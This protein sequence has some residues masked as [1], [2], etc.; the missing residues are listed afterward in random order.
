MNGDVLIQ[1]IIN[2]FVMAI[3]LEAAIMAIFSM[4]AFRDM[5]MTR[6]VEATRDVIVLL[7][8]F[9]LC[10]K[11]DVLHVFRGTG[12]KIPV[13]FD[14]IISTLVLTRMTNFVRQVFNRLRQD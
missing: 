4:S 5:K 8:A 6:A 1:N 10:Y 3:I 14:I 12:L 9:F 13:L 2:L 7:A 11:V